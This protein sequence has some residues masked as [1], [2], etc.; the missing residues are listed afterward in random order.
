MFC[1]ENLFVFEKRYFETQQLCVF[2]S[3]ELDNYC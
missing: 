2:G 1:K 3:D